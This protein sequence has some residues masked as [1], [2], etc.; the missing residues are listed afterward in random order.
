MWQP[1]VCR[2]ALQEL[3]RALRGPAAHRTGVVKAQRLQPGAP[4][5]VDLSANPASTAMITGV[6]VP[7]SLTCFSS[8]CCSFFLR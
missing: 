8:C 5:A 2:C 4:E 7:F 6:K 1:F 3:N